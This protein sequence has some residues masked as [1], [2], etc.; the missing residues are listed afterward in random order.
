MI[1]QAEGMV[2]RPPSES[3]SF[4]LRVTIGCSHNTCTFCDM[5]KGVAFRIRPMSEIDELI[6]SGSK[7]YS[8]ARRAFLAD[9]DALVLPNDKLIHILDRL[10]E[11]FP[12]LNR[13][14]VY[15]TPTI[16]LRKTVAEL[17]ELKQHGLQIVYTGIESGSNEVLRRVCKGTTENE[18]IEGCRHALDA[19]LKLSTMI[20][21]GLGG[22]ELTD[23]HALATARVI[24]A[25]Q[26][27]MLSALTLIIAPGTPLHQQTVAGQF[28]PL[29]ARGLMIEL[30]NILS[31]ITVVKPCIF[32]SNHVSNLYPIGGT[33]PKD[34][35]LMLAQAKAIL[36]ELDDTTPLY[37]FNGNF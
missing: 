14:G 17:A 16:L 22:Q 24:N 5:Y 26:P 33:L 4:I 15:S 9:G 7:Y 12:H 20:I 28:L 13:V 27:T 29:T 10:Y 31:H 18:T 1:D 37:N 2:F 3:R 19:N 11:K 32:R 35:E 21:L 23:D 30:H 8:S 34:K 25:V 36:P 6:N